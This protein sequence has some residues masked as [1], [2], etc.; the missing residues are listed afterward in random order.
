MVTEPRPVKHLGPEQ[1]S[2]VADPTE[3]V[4]VEHRGFQGR[5]LL[6]SAEFREYVRRLEQAVRALLGPETGGPVFQLAG[7]LTVVDGVESAVEDLRGRERRAAANRFD[8]L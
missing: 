1:R 3:V 5:A 8:D 7:S 4:E 2:F 6:V